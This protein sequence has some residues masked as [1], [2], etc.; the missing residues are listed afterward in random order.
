MRKPVNPFPHTNW[1]PDRH[2]GE[3]CLL[4][5]P[6]RKSVTIKGWNNRLKAERDPAFAAAY[7]EAMAGAEPAEK[8]GLGMPRTGT[9]AAL[10]AQLYSHTIF[11]GKR[12]ATQR[13]LR[14]YVDRWATDEGDKPWALIEA[15]ACAEARQR[16][17][18]CRQ[19]RGRAQLPD[20]GASASQ[21]SGR[22]SARKKDDDPTEGV[23]LPKIK[24]KGYRTWTDDEAVTYETA[25]TYDTLERLIYEA[26]ACTGLRRSDIGRLRRGHVQPRK[27]IAC[28]GRHKVTHDLVLPWIEKNDEALRLP[29]LPW[30]QRAL[31][32]LP[33]GNVTWLM[34]PDDRPLIARP[35]GKPLSA[36]RIADILS[37][38]CLAIGLKPKIVDAT[39]K[40]KGLSGHGLRKRM[41][42]RLAELC[43]CSE[44]KIMSVLGQRDPRSAKIYTEAAKRNRMAEDALFELLALVDEE[45]PGTSGSHTPASASHTALN[46]LK[47]RG[48]K[49]AKR[50][51]PGQAR[52]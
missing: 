17:C 37:E 44:L 48:S 45:Q 4:R 23:E 38:A 49:M 27:K 30:L 5:V 1:M 34:A 33:A 16:L 2:G 40:P 9:L 52:P 25:Y 6:G 13:T 41:A 50:G 19:G 35:D 31:D 47:A 51:W 46:L 36:K 32:E 29:I 42:T 24:G 39:G 21:G 15:R 20:R 43:G 28:I 10:R 3:R 14:S 26:Y 18:R 12:P 8:K 22:R 11:T 7:R